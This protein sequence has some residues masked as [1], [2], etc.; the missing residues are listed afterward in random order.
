MS[1]SDPMDCSTPGFP[2]LHCLLEFAKTWVHW[3]H[4]A[5]QLSHSLSPLSPALNLFEHQGLFQWK[6]QLFA[7][8]GQSIGVSA[9]ASVLPMNIQGWFPL[10]LTGLISLLSKGFSSLLQ[11]HISKAS[12]LWCSA[13]FM[14]QLSHSYMTTGKTMA[15]TIQT[16]VGK[17]TS[18]L[19]NTLSL[20]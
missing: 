2:V 15:L 13:F 4:D 8:G 5:I 16:F 7:S 6:R 12:I 10:G 11:H 1:D 9:W 20:S 14:V 18:L 17:A 19:F 3:V